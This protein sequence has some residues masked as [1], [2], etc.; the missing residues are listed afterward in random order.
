MKIGNRLLDG[1]SIFLQKLI[2]KYQLEENI[3]YLG[4]IDETQIVKELQQCNVCVI[5]SF[6]ETYCLAFAE[7]M[8]IGAPTIA[9]YAGAMPELGD[10]K[11]EC[12]F[13]NPSD[14]HMCA[15]YIDKLIQNKELAET[16]SYNGRQKRLIENDP[17]TVLKTQ[18][19][20]YNNILL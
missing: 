19:E 17:Q 5:P 7:S 4:P 14:F 12:L 10:H 8:I 16:L 18:L 13:Y 11:K 1:Y 2:R 20:I 15:Y 9:S 3:V 6:V